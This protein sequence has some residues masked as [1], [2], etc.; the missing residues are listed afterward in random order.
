MERC[1]GP[2]GGFGTEIYSGQ[3]NCSGIC[4]YLEQGGYMENNAALT[5]TVYNAKCYLGEDILFANRRR[6]SFVSQL[7]TNEIDPALPSINAPNITT[8]RRTISNLSSII[9]K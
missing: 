3:N 5:S 9:F 4:S 1:G 8:C 6:F 2:N 7:G